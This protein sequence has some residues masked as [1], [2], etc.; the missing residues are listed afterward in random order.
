MKAGGAEVP[1]HPVYG[2]Y[3]CGYVCFV[4]VC[5]V[6]RLCLWHVSVWLCVCAVVSVCGY[7]CVS[8]V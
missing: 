6:G 1:R 8:G 2:M 5:V 4:C 7:V 3:L